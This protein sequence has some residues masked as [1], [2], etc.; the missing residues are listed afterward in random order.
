MKT[1]HRNLVPTTLAAFALAAVLAGST[2]AA[3]T[4]A[5]LD[6][7]ER[8][9]AAHVAANGNAESLGIA[10]AQSAP[11]DWPERWEAAHVA[12]NGNAESLRTAKAHAAAAAS[13]DW[14]ER[15]AAA[16][17]G[18]VGLARTLLA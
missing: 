10:K 11:L 14:P 2:S 9:Q 3:R 7:P 13:P 5:P 17:L 18:S 15:W 4:S 1:A 8:W 6:W 12:A 16:H